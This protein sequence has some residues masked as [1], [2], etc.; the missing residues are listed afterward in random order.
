LALKLGNHASFPTLYNAMIAAGIQTDDQMHWSKPA[1]PPSSYDSWWFNDQPKSVDVEMTAYA[2][3]VLIGKD[4]ALAL[5]TAKWLVSMKNSF[6]GYGSTQDTVQAL[7]ALSIFTWAFNDDAETFNIELTT[8]V[9]SVFNVQ[10]NPSNK[11]VV[12]EF[13]LNPL[14]RELDIYAGANSTGNAVVTLV[15]NFYEKSNETAPRFNIRTQLID[16]CRNLLKHQ[17]CIS[18]IALNEDVESN[19][20]LMKMTFPSGYVYDEGQKLFEGI[21]VCFRHS[22][23]KLCFD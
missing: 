19:M 3:R 18:Y 22:E 4:N 2:L 14:A 11:L 17:V 12:Q 1:P 20:A 21:R 7:N 9:G 8:N 13:A 6:G 16:P 23:F 15:C 10:V 5:K